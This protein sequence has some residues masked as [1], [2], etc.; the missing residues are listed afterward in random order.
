MVCFCFISGSHVSLSHLKWN[1]RFCFISGRYKHVMEKKLWILEWF[2]IS[3]L[4]ELWII[5]NIFLC[6]PQHSR[7]SGLYDH[8]KTIQC[9]DITIRERQLHLFEF[10]PILILCFFSE[11]LPFKRM[12]LIANI[13]WCT[14]VFLQVFKLV[15]LKLST[16][17]IRAKIVTKTSVLFAKYVYWIWLILYMERNNRI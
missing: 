5:S 8:T 13:I 10:Y 16:P 6:W 17:K 15:D 9:K 7:N 4:C 14:A 3:D 11:F 12:K 2:L 1:R